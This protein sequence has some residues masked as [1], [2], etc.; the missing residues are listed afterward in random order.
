MGLLI[1][2]TQVYFS[3]LLLI[4]GSWKCVSL[5]QAWHYTASSSPPLGKPPAVFYITLPAELT[6]GAIVQRL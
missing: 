4:L 6:P 1:S 3:Y 2:D 5:H